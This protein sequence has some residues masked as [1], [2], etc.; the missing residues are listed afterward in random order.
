MDELIKKVTE[1]FTEYLLGSLQFQEK[2]EGIVEGKMATL[3]AVDESRVN[4]LIDDK[5]EIFEVET[6]PQTIRDVVR[7]MDFTIEVGRY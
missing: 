4:E 7:N 2:V 3:T 6:D 5:L 1:A